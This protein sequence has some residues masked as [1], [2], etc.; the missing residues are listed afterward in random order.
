V[1]LLITVVFL[2]LQWLQGG[3]TSS[4]IGVQLVHHSH[5]GLI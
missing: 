3:S 2:G 4:A 5:G 1:A